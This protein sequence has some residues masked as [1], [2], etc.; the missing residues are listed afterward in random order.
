M[1]GFFTGVQWFFEEILFAPFNAMARLELE[2]WAAAN[3]MSWLF[4]IVGFL[5][6]FY[7]MK[8]L[9]IFKANDED[10]TDVT[11]HDFL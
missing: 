1:E 8:Q 11:A 6:F 3:F 9:R 2:S 10:R 5:A 4:I 7:W